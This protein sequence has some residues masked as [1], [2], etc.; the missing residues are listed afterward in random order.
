MIIKSVTFETELA[1]EGRLEQKITNDLSS[2]KEFE[3]CLSAEAWRHSTKNEVSYTLV[4]KWQ[5]KKDFQAWLKR[6]EH[7]Q[8]HRKAHQQKVEPPH[9]ITRTR[10]EEYTLFE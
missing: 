7:L 4:T 1:G 10:M 5:D 3:T 6:P 8:E 2:L 9:E